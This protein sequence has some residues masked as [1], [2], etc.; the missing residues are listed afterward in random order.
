MNANTNPRSMIGVV[1]G[2]GPYAGLDLCRKIF[3]QTKARRDQDHLPVSLLSLPHEIADRTGFLLGD[4]EVNPGLAIGGIVCALGQQG[5]TVVGIPCN[6]AHA[7]AIFDEI[8]ARVPNG[9][10]LVHMIDETIQH[11]RSH[12]PTVTKVGV[13]S[14]TGTWRCEVYP[15]ALSRHGLAGLAVSADVQENLIQPAIYD[16]GFGIKGQ[17]NPV[18]AKAKDCLRKGI[19]TLLE[20]GAQAVILGCTEIPLALP[21]SQLHGVP[22]IDPTRILARALIREFSPEHLMPNICESEET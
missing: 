19:V 15:E 2:V 7:P 21:E 16:P 4:A 20:Q 5:A 18:T 12:Y 22:L 13:I 9:V 10:T 6:T 11:L 14:T 8:A 1:G 3:D 17:S